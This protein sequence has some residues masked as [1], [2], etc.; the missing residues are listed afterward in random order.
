MLTEIAITKLKQPEK[1]KSYP[2]GVPGLFLLHHPTGEKSWALQYRRDGV[3][4]KLTIG[5]CPTIGLAQA[6]KL[7]RAALGEVAKGNDPAAAKQAARASAKA[8]READVDRVEKVVELFIERHA[9]PNIKRWRETQRIL[10]S[11][12]RPFVGRGGG[13]LN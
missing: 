5:S 8:K 9:K 4:R 3:Q 1:R 6:R 11:R 2:A 12:G 10:E 13:S 7:A